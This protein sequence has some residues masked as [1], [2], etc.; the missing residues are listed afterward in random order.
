MMLI[1]LSCWEEWSKTRKGPGQVHQSEGL[2]PHALS[3]A[4]L[5]GKEQLTGYHIV[6]DQ[7]QYVLP[8]RIEYGKQSRNHRMNEKAMSDGI[9][10]CAW[11]SRQIV[12]MFCHKCD[13]EDREE[14][15]SDWGL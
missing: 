2:D 10:S 12:E 3:L 8:G 11:K 9:S 13:I 6:H 14:Y 4:S 1:E 7:F 5:A 15:R